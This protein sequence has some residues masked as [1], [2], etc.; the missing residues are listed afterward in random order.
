MEEPIRGDGAAKKI[1]EGNMPWTLLIQMNRSL[2]SID[3]EYGSRYLHFKRPLLTWAVQNVCV[4]AHTF[5]VGL[6]RFRF[7]YFACNHLCLRF[8]VTRMPAQLLIF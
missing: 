7:F 2:T 8:K 4:C 5:K 6:L 1:K 3:V